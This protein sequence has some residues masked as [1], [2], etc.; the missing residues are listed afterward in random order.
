MLWWG[1]LATI[2]LMGA[3]IVLP[4]FLN[5]DY[6]KTLALQQIQRMFGS[7]VSVGQ[8]SFALF[9][10]PHFLVTDIVV[11][12]LPESHAV[13]RAQSMSLELGIGQ[14]L[15]KKIVVREFLVD[16]P[17]IELRRDPTGEWRFLSHSSDD[18]PIVSL[19]KFLVM[20]KFVVTG[21]KIIIIDESPRE[22][23]R[24]FVIEDVTCLSETFHEASSI[25]STFE[26]SGKL[27][28]AHRSAPFH[29]Q[30][31]LDALLSSP[32][33][34]IG[35]RPV[36]FD[37]VTFSGQVR[38]DHVEVNQIGDYLPNGE[39]LSEFPGTFN[40]KSQVKWVQNSKT[41]QLYLTNIDLSSSS[42]T[43]G[44]TA[45]IE[46]LEDGH[47]MTGFSMRSS[48][49]DLEM[50]RHYVPKSW[51]P[52]DILPLWE[53]GQ[54]G[55]KL[56]IAE[57]RVTGSTREDVGTSVT[58]TFQLTNGYVSIPDWP[59]T[60]QIQG[61]VVVEP[62]RVKLS[63]VHGI[64]DGIPI[65]VT[66]GVFYFKDSRPW[67][68]VQIQ[69]PVPAEKVF[70]VIAQ[71]GAPSDFGILKSWKVSQGSGGLRLRF[72][73]NLFD[74]PGLKFQYGEYQPQD[75]VIHI[76]GFPH[77]FSKGHGRIIFSRESTVLEGIQGDVG[78]YPLML[79]GT[80]TH[81]GES[82]FEPL[83]ITAGFEGQDVLPASS[84]HKNASGIQ[85]TGPLKASVTLTGSTR[86]PKIKAWVDGEG[87]SI[88][89]PSVLQKHAGQEGTLEFDGQFH[90][91][92]IIRFERV[93]LV[94]LP[95]RLRG[96]GAIRYRPDVTWEGRLDS[97]PIYVG[98]L[99]EGIRVL[100]DIIQAG[101]L[102][103][104]LKGSGQGS[105]WTRWNTKGWV[106]LTE[107]VVAI[108]GVQDPI[109]NLFMRLKVDRD[110]LD[111]KRMEFRL[112]DSE[113][114]ITGFMKNW[115]TTPVVSVMLEAPQFDIELLIP[116]SERSA[117][118]D[119]IEWLAAHGTLEGSVHIERPTYKNLFGKK[120]S[121][122]LK[123]HD[124]LVSVDKVQTMVEE[125]GSFRGRFFIHLPQGKPAAMR[126]SFQ[127]NDLPFEKILNVLGDER[128]LITGNMNVR[129]MIQGNGR[130]RRGVIPTLNGS[131]EFSLREG[132]VRKGT[133]L[134]RILAL[135][136]LPNVLRGKVDLEETGFP[137]K[138]VSSKVK[139]EEG[140]FS[141]KNFFLNSSIMKASAAGMYDLHHDRLEGI[142]AVSPFGAYSDLLKK[143]PL[144]GRIFSGDRKGIATAMFSVAGPLDDPKV[145]YMP[146]ESLQTGLT[147]LAD[148]A[149]DILKNTISL[150]YD[151]LKESI[152]DPS[153]APKEAEPS[154]TTIHP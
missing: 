79:S 74:S 30:G 86:H 96:Q 132:Y 17:E 93:E 72:S 138:K 108:P 7:H 75:L 129:G 80:I 22:I 137:F 105:D 68:D 144:F 115:K 38:A 118:R 45:N 53:K 82:R 103:I 97:G 10:Q 33:P 59:K 147:G 52:E 120:L 26:L 61:T 44:G 67:G 127:A 43:L 152:E 64:Y 42:I 84:R 98:L 104:Q 47:Q 141:T 9:P 29:I 15:V 27:R 2:G 23:V 134:P 19:A 125:N 60:E 13:F 49:V 66:E 150:P 63:E 40:V 48:N 32:V 83:N 37:Q 130:D 111:L 128:R 88:D 71:L 36:V 56:D 101:I 39:S 92:G 24:G 41:S 124:N 109:S 8:T 146:L 114:V 91:G 51:I 112:K 16:G 11:K 18:S 107:G 69:G 100:G 62:D 122:A 77:P 81:Q 99:P 148:L 12:E 135:L 87:A 28:Q 117:I 149:I 140:I 151:L 78:A 145:E 85:V 116:K 3:L 31:Q 57:A 54:W 55:G 133:I 95:L 143:I 70:S 46:V 123:I 4:W 58:G 139:I 14:L 94:M 131:V 106:A 142:A 34:S 73:G 90:P 89:V 5:P 102:E 21:G 113:A 110:R 153:S 136:N 126:A 76:P 154:G 25:S 1:G 20:G 119:G 121:A 35:S 65:D 6:L 50:V